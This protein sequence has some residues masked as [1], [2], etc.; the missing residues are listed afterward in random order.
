MLLSGL[1]ICL[2]S[3]ASAIVYATDGSM[4]L[5]CVSLVLLVIGAGLSIPAAGRMEEIPCW[6][7]QKWNTTPY[8]PR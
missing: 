6:P 7:C 2:L 8:N 4:I 1:I 5:L 3:L